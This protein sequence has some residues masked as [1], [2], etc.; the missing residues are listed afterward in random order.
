MKFYTTLYADENILYFNRDSGCV[1][2]SCNEIRI[3][4]I[5]INNTNL[6]NHFE[7]L[8]KDDGDTIILMRHLA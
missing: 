8:L 7:I 6:D 1:V 5:D 3:F 4:V 2:F